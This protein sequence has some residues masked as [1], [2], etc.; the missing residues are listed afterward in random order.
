[1]QM[2]STLVWNH[3]KLMTHPSRIWMDVLPEDKQVKLT[4]LADTG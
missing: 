3:Q 2:L 4:I 1:M